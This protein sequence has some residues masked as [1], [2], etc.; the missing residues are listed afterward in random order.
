MKKSNLGSVFAQY[1]VII[2]LS[3][4]LL[5]F[6]TKYFIDDQKGIVFGLILGLSA[7][8]VSVVSW[9]LVFLRRKTSIDF[10]IFIISTGSINFYC[11]IHAFS[12]FPEIIEYPLPFIVNLLITS[13]MIATVILG[14]RLIKSNYMN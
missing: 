12:S 13:G 7:V 14:Y 8:L 6:S 9:M 3:Y 11:F 1:L 10:Q 4:T 5:F 2:S